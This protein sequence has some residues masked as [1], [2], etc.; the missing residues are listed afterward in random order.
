MMK[1]T[2][3]YLL[4]IPLVLLACGNSHKQQEQPIAEV[5]KEVSTPVYPIHIPFEKG[6]GTER[7]VKLSDIAES[8]EFIPLETTDT[9]LIKSLKQTNLIRTSKYFIL[10][11]MQNVFQFTLDGK[12]VRKIGRRG[13]GPGEY[14]YVTQVDVNEA[15]NLISIYSWS[16]Q[17]TN[18]YD[19]ETG[20][21]IRSIHDPHNASITCM[22]NDSTFISHVINSNG[23]QEIKLYF[24]DMQGNM[25]KSFKRPEKFI[26][27]IAGASIRSTFDHYFY[28]YNDEFCY[29]EYENDT[30]YIASPQELKKKYI[31]DLG[32]YSIPTEHTIS[33]I[34]DVKKY[35]DVAAGYIR[36]SV[37]ETT[38]YLFFPY[39]HW[40]GEKLNKIQFMMY[41]K[42][43]AECFCIKGDKIINDF[44]PGLDL[45]PFW[46]IDENTLIMELSANEIYE[47]AEK[48]PD[49]LKHPQLK[50]IKVDDN[51]V[52]MLV[53]L[54]E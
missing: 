30:V 51:P 41:N 28:Q 19:L 5:T 13:Q 20:T 27:K 16:S 48:N 7:E 4:V 43:T 23:Q 49:L 52:L 3:A 26:C 35:N 2:H 50:N 31:L 17:K 38:N 1:R 9:S 44:I 40:A 29:K 6:M 32:K 47:E 53:K 18:L 24:S 36:T 33:Y 37:I 42:K 15:T 22:Y 46:T 10:P 39:S 11:E 34:G 45:Q 54:K 12:F 8:V 21:F 14:L 25:Q